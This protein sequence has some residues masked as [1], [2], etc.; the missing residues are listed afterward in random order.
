[1]RFLRSVR[2]RFT[3]W[4]LIILAILL[5]GLAIGLHAFLSHT[6][7]RNQ[8]FALES[9]AVQLAGSHEV[10]DALEEGR[11]EEG[12]GEIVAFFQQSGS[13]Y[14]VTSARLAEQDIELAWI[15][16]AFL[17]VGINLP[18]LLKDDIQEYMHAILD[19]DWGEERNASG[20]WVINRHGICANRCA[21]Q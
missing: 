20:Q 13:G 9:R 21:N 17:G 1:M 6:L 11:V 8:D 16:A 18:M 10:R 7:Q 15:E 5:V 3:G 14:Q 19:Y 12:L 4:Y 2:A